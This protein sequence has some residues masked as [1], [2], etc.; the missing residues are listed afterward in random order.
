MISI[1]HSSAGNW[2]LPRSVRRALDAMTADPGRRWRVSELA[3]LADVSGR[4]LQ[5]QFMSFLGKSPLVA[6]QEMALEQARQALL[7]AG[8]RA[9][10]ADVAQRCGFMHFGR[11]SAAYRRRY[12]ETPSS[13]LKR[14][15][16]FA[17][18]V[19]KLP[20]VMPSR[21]QPMLMLA[22]FEIEAGDRAMAAHLADDLATA[23]GRAGVAVTHEARFARY[24]MSGSIRG[25][26]AHRRLLLQLVDQESGRQ[27]WAHRSE[28]ALLP[29]MAHEQLATRIIASLQPNLRRAEIERARAMPEAALGP[30]EL[31]LKAMPGVQSLDAEG[32][33][34]ALDLLERALALDPD[35]QLA[36]ALAAWAYAQRTIYH[37]ASHPGSEQARGLAL[38]RKALSLQ[39]D[40]T[41]LAVLGTALTL[42][43]ELD[44]AAHVIG[45]ALAIDGGC[46][47]AWSR[48]GWL[49]VYRGDADAAI[50]RFRIG[51]DLAPQDAL[52]FNSL[53]G[54]GCAHF[55]A[56]N[57]AEAA[58]WQQRAVLEHP[59]SAW[60]HR[61][62]CPAYLLTGAR[63]AAQRSLDALRA[64][65]PDLTLAEVRRGM[66]PLPESY[67]NLV[68]EAL[69]DLG[70]PQ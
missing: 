52:A 58:R 33:A 65:H 27:L 5:R 2:P 26:G 30:H 47:W 54:I 61:T 29:S 20:V 60:M 39:G 62:L 36:V 45:K 34:R 22:R 55:K 50:E 57:Y 69:S 21:D 16:R 56:G 40:A 13:T 64:H 15:I 67:R 63:P 70:L 46:A 19:S 4:T 9:T 23:L 44:G 42:L 28:D 35:S 41:T 43:D 48:S 66:P 3:S 7:K 14:Q 18:A 31:A 37:F 17:E 1:D 10:V 25:E 6:Q 11:F 49:E 68:L 38:A 8:P 59:S 32:N 51:L 24:R 12:G 53:V